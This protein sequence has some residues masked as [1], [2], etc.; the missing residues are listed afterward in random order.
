VWWRYVGWASSGNICYYGSS[1]ITSANGLDGR[2]LVQFIPRALVFIVIVGLYSTLFSFLRRPDTIQ[3][4]SHFTSG[5]TSSDANKGVQMGKVFRRFG[6]R[7]VS[8]PVPKPAVNPEAP[9]EQLEFVHIG[10]AKAWG[11]SPVLPPLPSLQSTGLD[12]HDDLPSGS[13]PPSPNPD[14]QP[15]YPNDPQLDDPVPPGRASMTSTEGFI[16]PNPSQRPSE[17]DTLVTASS[18]YASDSPPANDLH[19]PY[20]QRTLSQV[21]SVTTEED[22]KSLSSILDSDEMEIMPEGQRKIARQTLREFFEEN[23][24]PGLEDSGRGSGSGTNG[25]GAPM[26]ATA[27][28]NR[29]ASLLMLYFPL[30]VSDPELD[31]WGISALTDST[32]WSLVCRSCG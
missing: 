20:R 2:D 30:A 21:T 8:D 12:C 29:Q 16:T 3:L 26:S 13:R 24:A 25:K 32:W 5:G 23:R 14:G 22:S 7:G 4:S 17:T 1:P 11:S 15:P 6:G 19:R 9:W 18:K 28:F 31:T 10:N 27:Y